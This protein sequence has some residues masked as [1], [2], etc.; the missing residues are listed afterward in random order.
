MNWYNRQLKISQRKGRVWTNEELEKIKN[1]FEQGFSQTQIA[2][3][4]GV[5][6]QPIKN[7]N[8]KYKW[9]NFKADRSKYDSFLADLYLLPPKGKGMSAKQIYKQHGFSTGKLYKALERLNL[10][11][12]WRGQSDAQKHMNL[13]NP[14]AAKE[15][16]N[17]MKQRFIDNPELREELSRFQKQKFIDNPD[18]REEYS[19]RMTQQWKDIGGYEGKLKSTSTKEQAINLLNNLMKIIIRDEGGRKSFNT[20]NKYMNIINNHIYPN[21]IQQGSPI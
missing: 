11:D 8:K 9:K 12:H 21:E 18:L 15:K 6:A 14:D 3:F 20:Y 17:T 16:S 10:L 2:S 4:F 1:M 19:Q 7:L 13:T 5:S